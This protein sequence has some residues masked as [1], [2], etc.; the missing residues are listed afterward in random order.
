MRARELLPWRS[1][2][3]DTSWPPEAAFVE[4]KKF[5]DPRW[6]IDG[7]GEAPTT[8]V[9]MARGVWSVW[10]GFEP[11]RRGG[12]QVQATMRLRPAIAM[13]AML[14]A[15]GAVP[16]TVIALG[17][18][19]NEGRLELAPFL[20]GLVLANVLAMFWFVHD[21]RFAEGELRA[22][23][24]LAPALPEPPESDRPFR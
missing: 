3:I 1:V 11:A 10:V 15:T 18:V 7:R 2:T 12:T 20:V 8:G 14:W 9:T 4:L 17:K 21:A 22:V 6:P 19:L 24:R 13:V 5:V 23:Y 16:W